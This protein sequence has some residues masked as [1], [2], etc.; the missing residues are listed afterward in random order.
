MSPGESEIDLASLSTGQS[1]DVSTLPK[2]LQDAF[3]IHKPDKNNGGGYTTLCNINST[4]VPD[5]GSAESDLFQLLLHR[6]WLTEKMIRHGKC[7]PDLV[8]QRARIYH[9]LQYHDLAAFDAYTVYILCQEE[10]SD[11]FV[12]DLVAHDLGGRP[13]LESTAEGSGNEQRIHIAR[14]EQVQALV[15]LVRCLAQMGATADAAKMRQELREELS[16]L[17]NTN[18]DDW[19]ATELP[20]AERDMDEI[21]RLLDVSTT[22]HFGHSRR[23]IYP[24]SSYEPERNS[25]ESVAELDKYLS[26]ISS[27]LEAKVT[28][29]P[30][31]DT[32]GN[33]IED[34][35]YQLG[36]FAKTDLQPGQEVLNERSLLTAIR[37]LEDAICDACGQELEEIPFEDVRQCDGDDCDVTFCSQECKDRAAKEYHR[38]NIYEEEDGDFD[39]DG[40]DAEDDTGE[41]SGHEAD[42]RVTTTNSRD[43]NAHEE[44]STS[45]TS[46]APICGNTDLST[47]GRPTNATTP[48][49]DLYFLLL[50]RT[51][52]MSL[53]QSIHPLSLPST[54]YLWGDF[55]PTPTPNTHKHHLTLPFSPLHNLQYTLDYFTTLSLSDPRA[56]PYSPHWLRTFDFW[57][58]QTL[59]AKF[60]GV[61]NATQSTFDGK[62]EIASVH[63]GWCLA[64]HSC[65]PN[66]RW[67]PKGTR[68][69]FVRT[70]EERAEYKRGEGGDDGDE[71]TGIKA[72]EEIF[73]HYTD[74]RLPVQERRERLKEVLGGDCRCERCVVESRDVAGH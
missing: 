38:P 44:V 29:L 3:L 62:P 40:E 49:W 16:M 59:F 69:F 39:G 46:S 23:E 18:S 43:E 60:R 30:A 66:V 27:Y 26:E 72:G 64:N 52:A 58:L 32:L 55:N 12:T 28:A 63:P 11:E 21:D 70:K 37:P 2:Y 61:A 54:K 9:A 5:P 53:T 50:T 25:T 6:E 56:T 35:S 7:H 74:I 20:N 71:W 47:I 24:W 1:I 4:D 15:V 68:K 10:L 31:F 13:W 17:K 48:E 36:L 67:T 73:S 22:S 51:I 14:Y 45:E 41:T 33:A 65:D 34:K 57:I 8:L 42:D 19:R